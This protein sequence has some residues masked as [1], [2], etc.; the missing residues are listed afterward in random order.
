MPETTLLLRL[1][2]YVIPLATVIAG[3][4]AMSLGGRNNLLGGAALVGAGLAVGAIS[5]AYRFSVREDADREREEA[6]RRYFDMHG[7]WPD[8]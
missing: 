3:V 2:R 1:I 7:R 8:N 4:V 6:A 5:W